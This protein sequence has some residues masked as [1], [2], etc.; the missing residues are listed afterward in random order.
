LDVKIDSSIIFHFLV[1]CRVEDKVCLR[2]PMVQCDL[3]IT[4]VGEYS[5]KT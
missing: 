2:L 5:A 1:T 4:L 3:G